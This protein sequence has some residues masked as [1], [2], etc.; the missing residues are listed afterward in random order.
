M[1][2][3]IRLLICLSI[4]APRC[5]LEQQALPTPTIAEQEQVA[6]T[7]MNR[8]KTN[9]LHIHKSTTHTSSLMTAAISPCQRA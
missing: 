7:I 3:T 2:Q 6:L 1:S 4:I 9:N 8:L 5:V